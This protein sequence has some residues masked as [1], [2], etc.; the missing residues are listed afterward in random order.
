MT[1]SYDTNFM[2]PISTSWYKE[3]NLTRSKVMYVDSDRL[4]QALNVPLGTRYEIDEVTEH[5]C[6]GRIDIYGVPN[7]PYP[8]EYSLPVMHVESWNVLTD[9]LEDFESD[10]LLTFDELINTFEADTGHKI[11]W[12]KD[13]E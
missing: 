11:R 10:E 8:I 2:G 1:I 5:W 9:W 12:W 6:G 4:S 7:E 3:R 13:N